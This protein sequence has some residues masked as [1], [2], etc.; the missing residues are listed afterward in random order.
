MDVV[1]IQ[2][3]ILLTIKEVS[4]GID[5]SSSNMNYH[6]YYDTIGIE[7]NESGYH[8]AGDC[9]G[10]DAIPHYNIIEVKD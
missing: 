1:H 3:G 9:Y 2:S 8:Q 7:D 10:Y 4:I 6:Q 5:D